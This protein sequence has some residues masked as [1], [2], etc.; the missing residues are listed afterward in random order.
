MHDHCQGQELAQNH[1]TAAPTPAA[2]EWRYDVASNGPSPFVCL[3]RRLEQQQLHAKAAL[4]HGHVAL[5]ALARARAMLPE[6]MQ[7]PPQHTQSGGSGSQGTVAGQG[8]FDHTGA[9]GKPT[10]TMQVRPLGARCGVCLFWRCVSGV[11]VLRAVSGAS[12]LPCALGASV[13]AQCV[14]LALSIGK[15]QFWQRGRLYLLSQSCLPATCLPC[16]SKGASQQRT[17]SPPFLYTQ[18]SP[19]RVS[20]SLART[21]IWGC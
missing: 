8:A 19:H 10:G 4:Q 2:A 17:G 3:C 5:D 15:C 11:S 20:L 12:A 7:P 16:S 6:D 21:D 13:L 9:A 14:R 18:H 1:Y